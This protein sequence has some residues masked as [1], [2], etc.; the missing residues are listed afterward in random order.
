MNNKMFLFA[1]QG[2]VSPH[3]SNVLKFSGSYTFGQSCDPLRSN[4][5]DGLYKGMTF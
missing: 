2:I 3:P 1:F 5:G 4:P